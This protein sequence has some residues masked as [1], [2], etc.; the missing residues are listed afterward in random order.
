V[1]ALDVRGANF[2]GHEN[3]NYQHPAADSL[4][5]ASVGGS[6]LTDDRA[7]LREAVNDIRAFLR[8]NLAPTERLCP[9]KDRQADQAPLVRLI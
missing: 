3:T 6:R 8:T 9:S 5:V 1:H 2:G 4:A 7:K